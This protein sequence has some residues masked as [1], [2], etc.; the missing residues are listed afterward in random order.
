MSPDEIARL[1]VFLADEIKRERLT[2]ELHAALAAELAA[3]YVMF[4]RT[5]PQR[6]YCEECGFSGGAA[7]HHARCT[8]YDRYRRLGT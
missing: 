3:H 7:G 8:K 6:H 1:A 4:E 2:G 5:E